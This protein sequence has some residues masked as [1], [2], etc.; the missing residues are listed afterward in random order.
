MTDR[1][2]IPYCASAI[3]AALYHAV[4][5]QRVAHVGIDDIRAAVVGYLSAG[6]CF[7]SDDD[8][9]LLVEASLRNV[10]EKVG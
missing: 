4:Q 1:L 3:S 5:N 10:V 6:T 2:N 8:F 7:L 9:E